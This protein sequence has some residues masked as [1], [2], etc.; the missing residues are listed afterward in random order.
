[1]IERTQLFTTVPT[2]K[3]TFPALLYS[4]SR[5]RKC[6]ALNCN[7]SKTLLAIKAHLMAQW[8]D[9]NISNINVEHKKQHKAGE[10]DNSAV[11]SSCWSS[12]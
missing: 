8:T 11:E 10:S 3:N 5:N 6:Y 7:I 4:S 2:K 9:E 12:R 1:M